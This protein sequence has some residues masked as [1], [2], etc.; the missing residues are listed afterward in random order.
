MTTEHLL[1]V[2]S[3]TTTSAVSPGSHQWR[4]VVR[5]LL[6][7]LDH[8]LGMAVFTQRT[9]ISTW[10]IHKKEKTSFSGSVLYSQWNSEKGGT[11]LLILIRNHFD[12]DSGAIYTSKNF[13]RECGIVRLDLAVLGWKWAE[14]SW[15]PEYSWAWLSIICI[16]F[17]LFFG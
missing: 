1:Q 10:V 8:L 12:G 5:K 3:N 4:L 13:W 11:S 7:S 16:S 14:L 6:S 9:R 17:C 15:A 2:C